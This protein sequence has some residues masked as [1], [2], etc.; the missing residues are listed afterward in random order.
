MILH[1]GTHLH[2]DLKWRERYP[3]YW[4][5]GQMR[6]WHSLSTMP[7]PSLLR[8]P[9]AGC[10]HPFLW[11]I[12]SLHTLLIENYTCITVFLC[13]ISLHLS[14]VLTIIFTYLSVSMDYT[15]IP[16]S[17][18]SNTILHQLPILIVLVGVPTSDILIPAPKEKRTNLRKNNKL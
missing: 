9:L 11:S 15:P 10:H 12:S 3:Y 16:K 17:N 2:H 4:P 7:I 18:P 5:Q 14:T 1:L 13:L 6:D 8:M